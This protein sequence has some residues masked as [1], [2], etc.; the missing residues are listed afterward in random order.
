MNEYGPKIYN[1][2]YV[3]N[4]SEGLNSHLLV[5]LSLTET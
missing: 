1:L 3:L 4:Y 2:V 5:E